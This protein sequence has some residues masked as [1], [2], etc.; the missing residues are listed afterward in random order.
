MLH[1]LFI[2]DVEDYKGLSPANV[3]YPKCIEFIC[4]DP[5]CYIA[6][7]E[8]K[9]SIDAEGQKNPEPNEVA[10]PMMQRGLD[11]TEVK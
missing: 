9:E 3:N 1:E 10:I 5:F 2:R 11:P 8:K 4:T 6:C 7:Q